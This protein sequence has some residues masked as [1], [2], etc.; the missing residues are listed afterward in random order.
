MLLMQFMNLCTVRRYRTKIDRAGVFIQ[1][2]VENG[3]S[4]L[5][6]GKLYLAKYLLTNYVKADVMATIW[7]I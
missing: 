7:Q 1:G 6:V 2:L 3:L 4:S 5:F